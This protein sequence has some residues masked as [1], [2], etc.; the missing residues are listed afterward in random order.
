MLVKMGLRD[1]IVLNRILVTARFSPDGT[2]APK[3]QWPGRIKVKK[4]ASRFPLTV[5]MTASGRSVMTNMLY[6]QGVTVQIDVFARYL[7]RLMTKTEE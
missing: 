7:E 4:A 1:R 5:W 2:G 3:L 6:N